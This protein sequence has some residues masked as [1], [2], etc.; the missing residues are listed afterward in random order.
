MGKIILFAS[1]IAILT[2]S[3]CIPPPP[4]LAAARKKQV[5]QHTQADSV[6]LQQMGYL[7]T[8]PVPIPPAAND[9]PLPASYTTEMKDIFFKSGDNYFEHLV[10]IF[11]KHNNIDISDQLLRVNQKPSSQTVKYLDMNSM[12]EL[13]RKNGFAMYTLQGFILEDLLYLIKYNIPFYAALNSNC[14]LGLAGSRATFI[15]VSGYSSYT[16]EDLNSGRITYHGYV[17]Q[18]MKLQKF[19]EI[20]NTVYI[21]VKDQSN[22]DHVLAAW[23]G[24]HQ[25]NNLQKLPLLLTDRKLS[26]PQ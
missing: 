23:Q 19:I 14:D 3:D 24:F 12:F 9:I 10:S 5:E 1:I 21:P 15:L 25:K 20:A 11:L 8:Q 7:F 17:N 13:L 18:E 2:F 22:F 26:S 6:L 16:P 4:E